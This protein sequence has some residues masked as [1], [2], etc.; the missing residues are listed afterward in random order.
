MWSFGNLNTQEHKFTS[1]IHETKSLK[2]ARIIPGKHHVGIAFE[3]NDF[4]F[5]YEKNTHTFFEL[6]AEFGGF[7][8]FLELFI[9]FA[10]STFFNHLFLTKAISNL[11]F[12]KTSNN[13]LFKRRKGKRGMTKDMKLQ[14]YQNKLQENPELFPHMNSIAEDSKRIKVIKLDFCQV[15]CSYLQMTVCSC[16]RLC[17]VRKSQVV[18]L[19]E[20]GS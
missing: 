2:Q 8:Y 5:R 4:G 6:I 17:G 10:S 20:R 1:L 3:L 9:T 16:F 11:Y 19:Y 15:L 13:N 7:L 18:R 12:A 14:N